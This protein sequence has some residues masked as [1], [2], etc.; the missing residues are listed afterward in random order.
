MH[1]VREMISNAEDAPP[2]ASP[3]ALPHALLEGNAA[4]G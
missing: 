1:V 3:A 4:S 2:R